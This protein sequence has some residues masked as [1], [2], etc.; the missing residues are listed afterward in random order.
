MKILKIIALSVSIFTITGFG[1]KEWGIL[2]SLEHA[3]TQWNL[4]RLQTEYVIKHPIKYR[5]VSQFGVPRT[6]IE[7]G[8]TE[9]QAREWNQKTG[10]YFHW[11]QYQ[12]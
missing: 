6:T 11:E 2:Q 9:Y 12:E 8:K 4:K 7:D 10:T 3:L 1:L 5:E